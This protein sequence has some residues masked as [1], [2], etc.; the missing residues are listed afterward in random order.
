[1][2]SVDLELLRLDFETATIKVPRNGNYDWMNEDWIDTQQRIE[3]VQ[4]EKSATVLCET[5]RFAEKGPHSIEILVPHLYG[6]SEVV[7]HLL[8]KPTTSGLHESVVRQAVRVDLY[9]W[10]K[11]ISLNW[12]LLGYAP[13]GVQYCLL[14]TGF[15]AVSVGFLQLD[16]ASA[17]IR[18]L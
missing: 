18:P 13:G 8:S 9:S 14:P 17:R 10:G 4:A 7:A 3:L 15:P 2:Y 12:G 6:E 1:M 16:W 11:L 5:G